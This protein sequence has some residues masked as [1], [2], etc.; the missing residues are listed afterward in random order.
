MEKTALKLEYKNNS[1][2]VLF[3]CGYLLRYFGDQMKDFP[4][5][6]HTN[7]SITDYHKSTGISNSGLSLIRETPAKYH[8]KYLS[9]LYK[10]EETDSKN[11]G[12]IVHCMV[13]EPE[14]FQ[15]QFMVLPEGFTR[16]S[17]AN[18]QL[19]ADIQNS[20]KTPIKVPEF[21]EASKMAYSIRSNK[22]FKAIIDSRGK[23]RVENSLY[24]HHPSGIKLKSRPDWFCDDLI[25]DI[26]TTKSADEDTFCRSIGEYGYHRQAHIATTG[27]TKLIGK[28][29]KH[30]LLV[31]VESEA[32]YLTAAYMLDERAIETGRD[33]VEEAVETYHECLERNEWPGYPETI[34]TISLPT[35][36][37]G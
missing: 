19:Y 4:E 10:R 22:A 11:L 37:R 25:I 20:G 3:N 16:H 12:S 6:I 9:G 18:K 17:N 36:Y 30:V 5:G 13:L 32:P 23:G 29:Y 21:E 28:T 26:K 31:A 34:E 14:L 1:R 2:A 15:H 24:W 7:I 27:L 35:W 33:E 8:Y